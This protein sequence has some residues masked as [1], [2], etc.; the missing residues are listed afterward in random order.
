ME[1]VIDSNYLDIGVGGSGYT[2]IEAARRGW[3]SF[4]TDISPL[5]MKKAKQFAKSELG[6]KFPPGFIVASAESLPFRDAAFGKLTMIGVLEHVPDD[7]QTIR[8]IV[9]VLEPSGEFL[10]SVPNSYRR[11][12]PLLWLPKSRADRRVGHLRFYKAEDL[13]SEFAR[14]GFKLKSV[15]YTGNFPKVVQILLTKIVH[16]VE[17]RTSRIWWKLEELDIQMNRLPSGM[18]LHLVMKKRN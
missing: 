1:G 7:K 9:R 17:G 16:R 4:G 11:I 15:V 13:V 6:S 10:I 5:G 3:H 8:E 12:H 18:Q 2:V 14:Y